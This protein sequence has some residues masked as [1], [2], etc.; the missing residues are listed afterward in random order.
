[1]LVVWLGQSFLSAIRNSSV[2]ISEVKMYG[3]IWE[4]IWCLTVVS[5]EA[6]CTHFRGSV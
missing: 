5:I 4:C 2:R 6:E 1:M 3:Y